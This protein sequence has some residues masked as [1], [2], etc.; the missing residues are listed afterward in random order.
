M[1]LCKDF[2]KYKLQQATA[3]R[4]AYSWRLLELLMKF[5]STGWA[6]YSIE[7][8]A[9]A[10]DATDKQRADFAKLR[11][12]IIEPAIKELTQKDGWII[13]WEPIR[14]GSRKV[15]AIKFT[16]SRDPQGKLL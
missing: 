1:G 3:L 16:F 10:M 13:A 8:F 7:D 15:V 12:K 5:E 2:T 6:Q 11:T 14:K 4:S 9:T